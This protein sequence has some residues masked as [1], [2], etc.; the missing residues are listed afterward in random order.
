MKR[1]GQ[2]SHYARQGFL[3]LRSSWVP[4]LNDRVVDKNLNFVGVVKDVFGPV[5]AP[6][7]AVK[8]SVRNPSDYVGAVLYVETKKA[9][10]QG[11]EKQSRH[12]K[13]RPAPAKRG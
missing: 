1:L 9:K 12:V 11:K 6:F 2:V 4:N 10:G 8:P 5:E 3:I 7:I 13:K